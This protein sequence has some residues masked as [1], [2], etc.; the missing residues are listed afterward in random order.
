METR[1]LSTRWKVAALAGM[2]AVLAISVLGGFW[3]GLLALLVVFAILAI[4]K[5]F[6]RYRKFIYRAVCP[7]GVLA[8]GSSMLLDVLLINLIPDS[9]ERTFLSLALGLPLGIIPIHLLIE[10]YTAVRVEWITTL[11]PDI[12]EKE[13]RTFLRNLFLELNYPIMIVDDGEVKTT[14]G[15]GPS[16]PG[17]LLMR[18][19][20]PGLLFA[21]HGNAVA[22]ERAGKFS[23]VARSGVTFLGSY[24]RPRSVVDLRP[25]GNTNLPVEEVYTRDGVILSFNLGVFYQIRRAQQLPRAVTSPGVQPP[26]VP[27]VAAEE[28]LGQADFYELAM[29]AGTSVV[30]PREGDQFPVADQDVINA[31]YGISSWQGATE[32]VAA[33]MLRDVIAE[34][35]LDDIYQFE[36]G[37]LLPRKEIREEVMRRLNE[38]TTE[39]WGTEVTW[40]DI[41]TVNIP[42]Q[43]RDQL[44][45]KWLADW[46]GKVQMS[47]KQATIARGE[48]EAA[49][50]SAQETARARAQM[51]MITTITQAFQEMEKLG[52]SSEIE[53][54]IA[55]RLIEA[56]EKLATE[57]A[58]GIFFPT[59][60]L[61]IMGVMKQGMLSGLTPPTGGTSPPA[62]GSASSGTSPPTGNTSADGMSS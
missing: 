31:V 26:R 9:L 15:A 1:G 5:P 27:V 41:G 48:A 28:T 34:R 38:V 24:E 45:S 42:S 7:A 33:Y 4:G 49:A 25:Q 18:L 55:L 36:Q 54:I 11:D 30:P 22:L 51:Q 2:G 52:A 60:L 3:A 50:L 37:K 6:K 12:D 43:V 20:G 53:H 13:A 21:N 23:R 32:A 14:R 16:G 19:G 46:E 47:R 44:L 57:H 10:A 61:E 59:E 39:S 62:G 40:V 58:T 35:N 29:Q 17:G 8:L 56:L